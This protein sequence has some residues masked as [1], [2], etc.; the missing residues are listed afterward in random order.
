MRFLQ[1]LGFATLALTLPSPAPLDDS[2]AFADLEKK[3]LENGVVGELEARQGG[4]IGTAIQA[5]VS[6]LQDATDDNLA[7]IQLAASQIRNATTASVIITATAVIRTNLRLIAQ[8]IRDAIAAVVAATTGATGGIQ[9]AIA[10]LTQSEINTFVG[11]L[12]QLITLLRNIRAQ[13]VITQNLS[14]AVATAASAELTAIRALINPLVV[15][16]QAAAKAI[17]VASVVAQLT[18][19][20][21]R[22]ATQGLLNIAAQIVAAQ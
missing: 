9:G 15:P 3:A 1:V 12:Q 16:L 8:S 5:I 13:L 22:E 14:A 7:A 21:L 20:G 11:A 6:N 4:A 18:I 19:T 2:L 17:L 10:G